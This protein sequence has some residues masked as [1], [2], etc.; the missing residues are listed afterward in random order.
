MGSKFKLPILALLAAMTL[1]LQTAAAVVQ[2]S[3]SK[4]VGPTTSTASSSA[5]VEPKIKSC[6]EWK[7]DRVHDALIR[8]TVTKT[9]IQV[10][11]SKD[12]NL[13]R[14]KGAL[15]S[16]AGQAIDRLEAQLETDQSVLETAKNF[17]VIDCLYGHVMKLQDKKA[18]FNE[19]AAKLSAEEIAELMSAYANR[20]FGNHSTDL[21]PSANSTAEDRVR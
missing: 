7:S 11:K 12:P 3:S 10:T 9:Q 21:A 14:S 13:A 5:H 8:V 4:A 15:E 2:E 20:S 1:S 16:G 19:V 6:Q 18:A 17:S